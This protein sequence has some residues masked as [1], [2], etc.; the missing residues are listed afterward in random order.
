MDLEY[1]NHI[2]LGDCCDVLKR[3]PEKTF[4]L[5]VTSPPYADARKKSVPKKDKSVDE[6]LMKLL[7]YK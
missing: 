4:N 5:I 3:I 6:K 1:I 7:K 2:I